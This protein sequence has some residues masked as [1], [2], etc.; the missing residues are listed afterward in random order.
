MKS[1]IME[2]KIISGINSNNE[3]Y[4]KISTNLINKLSNNLNEK[5]SSNYL[6]QN[7]KKKQIKMNE[8]KPFVNTQLSSI[9][10]KNSNSNFDFDNLISNKI[11]DK[12]K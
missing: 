8:I 4:N 1:S 2:N 3:D 6:R 11:S 12:K 9:H 10:F 7:Y 5:L